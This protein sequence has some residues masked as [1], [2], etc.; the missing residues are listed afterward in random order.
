MNKTNI[1]NMGSVTYRGKFDGH[2][3]NKQFIR[4]YEKICDTYADQ[5]IAKQINV[6]SSS[7]SKTKLGYFIASRSQIR[8]LKSIVDDETRMA[9]SMKPRKRK[10]YKSSPSADN[11]TVT[12][13]A[14]DSVKVSKPQ[15]DVTKIKMEGVKVRQRRSKAGSEFK[16]ITINIPKN[17][18]GEITINVE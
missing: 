1:Q 5:E 10:H 18:T 12:P 3:K 15:E 16:S 17:L 2:T 8:A 13:I 11:D 6:P 4:L 14:N 9:R 7:F